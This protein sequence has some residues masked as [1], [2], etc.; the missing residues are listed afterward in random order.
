LKESLIITKLKAALSLLESRLRINSKHWKSKPRTGGFNVNDTSNT[1]S[2]RSQLVGRPGLEGMKEWMEQLG[3]TVRQLPRNSLRE[4]LLTTE[5]QSTDFGI[6]HVAGTKGKGSTCFFAECFLKEHGKRTGFPLTTGLLNSPPLITTRERI[7]I[8][9]VPVSEELFAASFFEVWDRLWSYVSYH[10]DGVELMPRYH[11]CIMLL[12]VHIFVK[13]K[14]DVAIYETGCG[15]EYDTTN[16]VQ[17]DVTG[18]TTLGLD[19]TRKLG[20][21]IENIAWQKA[22]IFKPG[23]PAFSCPQVPAAMGVLQDRAAEKGVTLSFVGVDSMLPFELHVLRQEVQRINASLAIALVN[24]FLRKN[25]ASKIASQEPEPL[26]RED[27]RL[28]VGQFFL[29]GRFQHVLDGVDEWFIDI[30]HNEVSLRP[31]TKWFI[32]TSSE[33]KR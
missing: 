8:N 15:G 18:I 19:H 20:P 28:G 7:R 17:P 3:Y 5:E 10:E 13:A 26:S 23:A 14:V 6:I 27:I 9:S 1:T 30:A 32:E 29:P 22:G 25:T 2:E 33:N 31:A 12:S 4:R 16:V 24:A 21:A 11:Q